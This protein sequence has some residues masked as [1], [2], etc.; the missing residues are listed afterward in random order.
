MRFRVIA[1][2]VL[3]LVLGIMLWRSCVPEKANPVEMARSVR[4]D[5]FDPPDAP[6]ETAYVLENE[7]LWTS[8]TA[9]GAGCTEIR[10][11]DYTTQAGIE[12][13]YDATQWLTIFRSVAAHGPLQE[14]A[15]PVLPQHHRRRDGL[16]LIEQEGILDLA[17]EAT[18][19]ETDGPQE[20]A[21]GGHELHFRTSSAKGVDLE[22]AV[23][24][25]PAAR[26]FEIDLEVRAR[27]NELTGSQLGM[28]LGTGGGILR[29]A[30]RFYPNPY[31]GAALLE[32]ERVDAVKIHHPGG[33]MAANR[34]SVERWNGEVAY[35][36]EGSKY[37]LSAIQTRDDKPFQGAV[38]EQL[39]DSVAYEE[40]V[41]A[42][43]KP[44]EREQLEAVA[45]ADYELRV[46]SCAAASVAEISA[47]V[48]LTPAETGVLLGEYY[49]RATKARDRSWS[50]AS[51]AG[52]FSMRVGLPA[53]RPERRSFLWYLG[54]KDPEI[55]DSGS[56][57]PLSTVVEGVDYDSSFFYRIFQ[58]DLVAPAILAVLRFF[59]SLAGNWGIAI[60]LM[61]ILVRALLFPVNRASQVKMATYQVKMGKVKPL[62][63]AVK[64]KHAGDAKKINE[65]TFKIYREHKISPPLGGC[66]PV[67]LQFPV[68]I[69]LFAALRCS[70]LLRQQPFFGWIHDLSRPD[71]LLDFGGPVLDFFPFTGVTTLNVLPMLMV[72]LWVVHQR[73][74]PKPV[75]PQQA[76]VQKMMT[77]MPIMF[78]LLLYNYAAGLSLYM[79]TS[80]S[81]GIFESRVIKKRWPVG[82]QKAA[83]GSKPLA[84]GA[85]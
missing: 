18:D 19:W 56:Y 50:R 60:I 3:W 26:H 24:L 1:Y 35:V 42:R 29:F 31:V 75:D 8:W 38:V 16:H 67:L 11:K 76:Q 66:L 62:L 13:P 54:P 34:A 44:A 71:A 27:T 7:Y 78:G 48:G 40:S 63:E 2:I 61:T 52:V 20:R 69:G 47:K 68:F 58:T 6:P 36:V 53:E 43:L 41:M 74:M 49:R 21:D 83:A 65:E 46:A 30:D 80:S 85:K 59:H 64:K 55:L 15:E 57:A 84:A 45:K 81:V 5:V 39:F 28:R 25:A 72:V 77:F 82:N 23:A 17:L 32:G 79:I 9:R 10:V 51:V 22:L 4:L 33:G 73:S 70:I 12:P 37:F 14:C